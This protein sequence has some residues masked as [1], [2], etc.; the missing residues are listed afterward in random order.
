MS[1]DEFD[2]LYPLVENHLNPAAG[3]VVG[4][5][6][7]CLFETYGEELAFVRRQNPLRVWTLV[8]GDD[9][10]MYLVSGPW[11]VNRVAYLVS[12]VPTAGGVT[13]LVRIESGREDGVEA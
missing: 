9:G 3:W 7:G 6:R 4:D 13:V 10:D 5:G 8:D 12:T 2:E 1:E 11:V